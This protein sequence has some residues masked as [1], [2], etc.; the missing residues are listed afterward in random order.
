MNQSGRLLYKQLLHSF[1]SASCVHCIPLFATFRKILCK[2][3]LQWFH[4]KLHAHQSSVAVPNVSSDIK[5]CVTCKALFSP[6]LKIFRNHFCC[7][8]CNLHVRHWCAWHAIY[9]GRR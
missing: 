5:D 9:N 6:I 1:S 4:S 3:F 2:S 8:L 7:L